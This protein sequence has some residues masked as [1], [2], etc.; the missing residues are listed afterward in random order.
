MSLFNQGDSNR[1]KSRAG[2]KELWVLEVP[3]QSRQAPVGTPAL[4][5]TGGLR[6]HMSFE[7]YKVELQGGTEHGRKDLNIFK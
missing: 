2:F 4:C 7:P 1:M 3:L 6:R 5:C